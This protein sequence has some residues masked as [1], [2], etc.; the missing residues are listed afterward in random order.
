MKIRNVKQ[1]D[2]AP[3]G[4]GF[5]TIAKFEFE[6]IDGVVIYNCAI[7]ESPNG[8]LLVY[9]PNTGSRSE[10]LSLAPAVRANVLS[11]I[12]EVIANVECRRAA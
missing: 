8:R 3:S 4:S 12:E 5:R 2:N 7:V 1:Y 9:G 10:V 11:M 6:P